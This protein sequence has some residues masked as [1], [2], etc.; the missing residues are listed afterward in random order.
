MV[1]EII[2]DERA[3]PESG[4]EKGAMPTITQDADSDPAIIEKAETES[5]QDMGRW[6]RIGII[7]VLNTV[8]MISAFD[9]TSICVILPVCSSLR[10][11][12]HC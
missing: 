6:R 5:L 2:R 8:T 4:A 10:S 3:E 11:A 1:N 7:F 12:N 9:A